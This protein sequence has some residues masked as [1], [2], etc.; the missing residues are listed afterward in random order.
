MPSAFDIHTTNKQR[1]Q[2]LSRRA[3]LLSHSVSL[4]RLR[5][6]LCQ[7]VRNQKHSISLEKQSAILT[8]TKICSVSAVHFFFVCSAY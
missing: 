3:L 1:P 4:L 2:R 8:Q 7:S 6:T 5:E